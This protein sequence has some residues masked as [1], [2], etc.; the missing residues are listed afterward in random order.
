MPRAKKP[1]PFLV[2][3]S[4]GTV[5]Q[6]S[7][8]QADSILGESTKPTAKT[9]AA[10]K[11]EK[12]A[13]P[14]KAKA[15]PAQKAAK[16]ARVKIAAKPEKAPEKAAAKAATPAAPEKSTATVRDVREAAKRAILRNGKPMPRRELFKTLTSGRHAL[17]IAGKD[18]VEN[19]A[20]MLYK[21]RDKSFQ[22]LKGQG[23]WVK[24]EPLPAS[25]EQTPAAN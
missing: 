2:I 1:T 6:L 9:M 12:A 17:N 21:D 10:P 14:A 16:P 20:T 7:Q 22:N 3:P 13:Q 15:A 11:K 23:F 24:G 4:T 5:I 8:A 25:A 18:P 19:M